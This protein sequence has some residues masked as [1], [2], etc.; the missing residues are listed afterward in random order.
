MILQEIHFKKGHEVLYA[1]KVRI[2]ESKIIVVVVRNGIEIVNVDIE[3]ASLVGD[4]IRH[5][6][7]ET[8]FLGLRAHFE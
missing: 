7:N 5:I 6:G 3:L 1:K 2:S 4:C 8:D